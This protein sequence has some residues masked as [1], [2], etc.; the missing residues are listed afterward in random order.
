MSTP[1]LP[2]AARRVVLASFMGSAFEWY[3]FSLYG[4]TAALVFNQVFFPEAD[5]AVGTLLALTTTAVGY[6]TRPIGG[7]VFGHFGDR[8]GRK[9]LLVLT[10]MIMGIPTILIGL[11]PGYATLGPVA[12]VILLLMRMLQG[13]GLGGEY[14][15]AA[16]ATIESVPRHRRGFFGAIPQIGNPAGGMLGSVVVLLCNTL[17]SDEQYAAWVWRVPFLLSGILLVYAMVVRLRLAETGDF[18]QAKRERK[19]ERAPLVALVRHHWRPL[20]LGL[21]A[22]SADA[23]SG[24]VAGAV[25]I[26]YTVTYLQM[27]NDISLVNNILPNVLSIPLMLWMGRFSDVIGRKRLFVWGLLATAVATFPLFGLMNT[28][29]LPLMVLGITIFKLCNSTQFAV[30]SAFLADVFPT[31]V[32]YTAVSVVYQVSSIIGGLTAPAAAAILIASNGSPWPLAVALFAVCALSAACAA[33]MR[34]ETGSPI[35]RTQGVK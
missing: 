20:L 19:V 32:R 26:A 9:K 23:V 11:L 3:D 4:T 14:A 13:I 29:V 28:K 33:A 21:G 2:K 24:N 27:S 34:T 12:P 5:A 31:E 25:V 16:L 22:R 17:T 7:I 30:Q 35:P 15:G 6:V 8:V 10:M 18:D 1:P